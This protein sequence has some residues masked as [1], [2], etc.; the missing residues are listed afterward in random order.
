MLKQKIAVSSTLLG[1][2]AL[3]RHAQTMVVTNHEYPRAWGLDL[4]TGGC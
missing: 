3:C 4:S 2:R 1:A